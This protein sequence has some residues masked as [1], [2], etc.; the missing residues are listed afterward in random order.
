MKIKA[1]LFLGFGIVLAL[2]VVVGACGWY[3]LTSLQGSIDD[4][5][6]Q[7]G[8]RGNANRARDAVT[9]ATVNELRMMNYRDDYKD[10]FEKTADDFKKAHE[11]SKAAAKV[12]LNK[13][14]K[15]NAAAFDTS[16]D[17]FQKAIGE[18]KKLQDDIVECGARRGAAAKNVLDAI[19]AMV[20]VADKSLTTQVADKT[21]TPEAFKRYQKYRKIRDANNRIIAAAYLYIGTNNKEKQDKYAQTWMD[22]IKT[23]DTLLG[24]VL[25]K[26]SG[27]PDE[28]KDAAKICK[29][30]LAIYKTE[31]MNY[32]GFNIDQQKAVLAMGTAAKNARTNVDKVLKGVVTAVGN[33]NDAAKETANFVTILIV[34][35]AVI[36]LVVGIIIAFMLIR[37][38]IGPVMAVVS[39]AEQVAIGDLD[40]KLNEGSDEMGVMGEKLNVMIDGLRARSEMAETIANGDLRVNVNVLSEKDTL[41]KA[42]ETMVA[43]LNDV[44][45][46]VQV[47]VGQVNSGATQVS[48]ASQSLSQGATEQAASLEEITSA[49]QQTG[50][51]TKEN[52]EAATEANGLA[53][54]AANA[55]NTGQQRMEQ[56]SGAMEKISANAEE[57]QKVIKTI[58]DI[59]FQTNLLALNAAV[60]AARAGQ[61]GKGFAVVAEEVR[62]LAARSAKAAGETADLIEG[63]NK[64]IQQGVEVAGQTGTAL[65]EIAEHVEKTTELV[66]QIANA[67]N[68]QAISI[69]Q[70]NESLQQVDTVTQ[71]NT[72]N[73][74]ETA[75]A[76]EEMS[77]QAATLQQLIG[78]FQLKGGSTSTA[79]VAQGSASTTTAASAASD[80]DG[81]FGKF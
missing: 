54:Q 37:S 59:A 2:L 50:S 27:A 18:W 61:H 39:G 41:G 6:V 10:H 79:A 63:S 21:I 34:T 48:D 70:V 23:V 30:A 31:V 51:Q 55:A 56:M 75:S 60:E 29:D 3:G 67:S 69:T 40:V 14:N 72:A 9:V 49:V 62:N 45:G 42:F 80:S 24:E 38:I 17:N 74:E 1:K 8:I 4:L 53:G 5:N 16:A 44:L 52:A 36:A 22:E 66:G 20:G 65:N 28:V 76:A 77:S 71:E 46:E 35:S 15:A 32:R 11:E 19:I 47:A 57:T 58:D 73:A 12:M 64:E 13:T 78:R 43:Q 68:E 26:D 7:N 33:A 81:D 25:D